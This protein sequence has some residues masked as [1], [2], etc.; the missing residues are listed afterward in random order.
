[1]KSFQSDVIAFGYIAQAWIQCEDNGASAVLQSFKEAM[2]RRIISEN[3][4]KGFDIRNI[5]AK[6]ETIAISAQQE[7]EIDI[8]HRLNETL[9]RS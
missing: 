3:S 9:N 2:K 6:V 7:L 4:F 8:K 5:L 1:M